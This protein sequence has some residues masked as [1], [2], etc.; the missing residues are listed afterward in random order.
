MYTAYK[1]DDNT[2]IWPILHNIQITGNII[3]FSEDIN[4]VGFYV[5]KMHQIIE[6]D[7]CIDMVSIIS[8]T[9]TD[10]S[11]DKL[12]KFATKCKPGIVLDILKEKIS[13]SINKERRNFSYEN[14]TKTSKL[15]TDFYN[16]KWPVGIN[17]PVEWRKLNNSTTIEDNSII[18]AVL[19]HIS[20]NDAKVEDVIIYEESYSY[21]ESDDINFINIDEELNEAIKSKNVKKVALLLLSTPRHHKLEQYLQWLI[22]V[23]INELYANFVIN[24]ALIMRMPNVKNSIKSPKIIDESIY[25]YEIKHIVDIAYLLYNICL[26]NEFIIYIC[27]ALCLPQYLLLLKEVNLIEIIK[28]CCKSHIKYES[29]FRASLACAIRNCNNAEYLK[30]YSYISKN[31][32]FV[33]TI[34]IAHTLS[35]GLGQSTINIFT[36]VPSKYLKLKTPF[37]VFDDKRKIV[38]LDELIFRINTTANRNVS[39]PRFTDIVPWKHLTLT[40]SRLATAGAIRPMESDYKC[41]QSYIC[42]YVG[43][44]E[45]LMDELFVEYKEL[46]TNDIEIIIDNNPKMKI[47]TDKCKLLTD[48]DLHHYGD[49]IDLDDVVKSFIE[50]L[51]KYGIAFMIKRPKFQ[52]TY[53]WTVYSE[54]LRY[55]MDIFSSIRNPINLINGFMTCYPK[56]YFD[57]KNA[58]CTCGYLSANVSGINYMYNRMINMDPIRVMMKSTTREQV[59]MLINYNE[60]EKLNKWLK[61]KNMPEAVYGNVSIKHSIFEKN[62]DNIDSETYWPRSKW[63]TP[64]SNIDIDIWDGDEMVTPPQYIFDLYYSEL[65]TITS[66][67]KN[68]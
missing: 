68:N 57:G 53:S 22:S 59:T 36:P 18:N 21:I 16:R 7:K 1:Q 13:I 26:I 15:V 35:H 56:I 10:I 5:D 17:S 48:I 43:T 6:T 60:S 12:L 24:L 20:I 46:K 23:N 2:I 28:S 37:F 8:F 4:P 65:S 41:F 14:V 32:I 62:N 55:P 49:F 44:C 42:D 25:I 34:D 50:T 51:R 45:Y 67:N 61:H 31:D 47:I 58:Y 64:I 29:I 11:C 54:I 27:S 38:K 63:L 30:L 40:G 66:N 39:G 19:R 33:F 3:L 52:E 9:S